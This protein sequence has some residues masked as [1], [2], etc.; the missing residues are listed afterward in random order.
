[1]RS[2]ADP[3]KLLAGRRIAVRCRIGAS[4]DSAYFSQLATRNSQ[5][6][7]RNSLLATRHPILMTRSVQ[8]LFEVEFELCVAVVAA[9]FTEQKTWLDIATVL[10]LVLRAAVF[11]TWTVDL[12]VVDLADLHVRID[13]HRLDAVHFQRPCAAVADISDAASGIDE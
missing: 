6:A 9:K 1:M 11:V 8:Q 10:V 7:T 2:D 12:H 3:A 4:L 13:S 5:L